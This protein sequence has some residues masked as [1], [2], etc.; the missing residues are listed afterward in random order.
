MSNFFDAYRE[1]L[2]R[3]HNALLQLADD[4]IKIDPEIEAY[5]YREERRLVSNVVFFKGEGYNSIGFHDVPYRWSGCGHGEFSYS[6]GGGENHSMPFTPEDV[7]K[8]MQPITT[9]IKGGDVRFKSKDQFLTWYSFYKRYNTGDKE[10]Q[11]IN[12]P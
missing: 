8:T 4:L 1:R 11:I 6:H 2:K 5:I 10:M 9:V 7:L 12:L 3:N